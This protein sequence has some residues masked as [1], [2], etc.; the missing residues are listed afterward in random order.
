MLVTIEPDTIQTQ[1]WWNNDKN[2]QNYSRAH[3][4]F[5][6]KGEDVV[7]V[8]KFS[9]KSFTNDSFELKVLMM[10]DNRPHKGKSN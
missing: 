6:A 5:V 2:W 10:N 8:V 9:F 3:H 7:E 4:S 1:F